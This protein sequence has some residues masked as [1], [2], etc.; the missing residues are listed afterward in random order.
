MTNKGRLCCD[1]ELK[2]LQSVRQRRDEP[3]GLEPLRALVKMFHPQRSDKSPG[4]DGSGGTN[5]VNLEKKK[6]F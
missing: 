6:L 5:F 4:S 2:K 1:R 3:Q